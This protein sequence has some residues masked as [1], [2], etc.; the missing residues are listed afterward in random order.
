MLAQWPLQA[1]PVVHTLPS[2][3]GMTW[4]LCDGGILVCR[5]QWSEDFDVADVPLA[6]AVVPY[7]YRISRVDPRED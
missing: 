7:Q 1:D 3:G 4:S 6:S 5:R 2:R